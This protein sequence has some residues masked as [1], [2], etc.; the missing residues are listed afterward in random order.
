VVDPSKDPKT[1]KMVDPTPLWTDAET[2][3]SVARACAERPKKRVPVRL[4]HGSGFKDQVGYVTNL[5]VGEDG[6]LR[7]DLH[8][9]SKHEK[10]DSLL[11]MAE[12]M[13]ESFGLSVSFNE[14]PPE[15]SADGS[16]AFVRCREA[17]FVDVVS[18][19]AANP[20]G[21]L[22]EGGAGAAV[23]RVEMGGGTDSAQ[24]R[25]N[26][27]RNG[28]RTFTAMAK[29][30]QDNT[31][32]EETAEELRARIAELEGELQEERDAGAELVAELEAAT[33]GEGEGEGGDDDGEG[34]GGD[35]D[36]EGEGEGAGDGEG[37]GEVEAA[38][39][40]LPGLAR[41]L[42]AELAWVKSFRQDVQRALAEEEAEAEARDLAE[43]EETVEAL[44]AEKERLLA[45][46]AALRGLSAGVGHA[47]AAPVVDHVRALA[48]GDNSP[49]IALKKQLME[50]KGL[51]AAVAVKH[52]RETVQ[53]GERMFQEWAKTRNLA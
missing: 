30:E 5:A 17:M 37:A 48:V 10:T 50:E 11:Q 53:D 24:T 13:P 12:E 15:K 33:A 29:N 44:A 25:S 35:D 43:I 34:A 49:F 31:T 41:E 9:M 2:V 21:M 4:D 6:K 3:A 23:R 8:L 26:P 52:I 38:L 51:S 40:A 16:K 27:N 46:N 45:E 42:R 39:S 20:D 1:G 32:G 18:R 7:G 47:G 22:S 19:A 36:G 28:N 14:D